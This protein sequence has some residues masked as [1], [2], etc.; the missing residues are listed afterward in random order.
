M[1][2]PVT[3]APTRYASVTNMPRCKQYW[4]DRQIAIL[5]KIRLIAAAP[6][7]SWATCCRVDAKLQHLSAQCIFQSPFGA[8]CSHRLELL[9]Q[10]QKEKRG[11]SVILSPR[12]EADAAVD[13]SFSSNCR[14][15]RDVWSCWMTWSGR[16]GTM[17]PSRPL[18]I[19][20]LTSWY[21]C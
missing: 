5:M 9:P 19:W 16:S 8:W 2:M 20:A 10:W 4:H 13:L 21:A 14:R 12:L 3:I 15:R 11:L 1:S 17:L 7:S 6:W 18:L